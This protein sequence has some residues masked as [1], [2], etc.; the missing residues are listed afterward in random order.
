[1]FSRWKLALET[2]ANF[3]ATRAGNSRW[4]PEPFS[5]AGFQREFGLQLGKLS[6]K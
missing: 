5:G 4:N 6:Q 2:S 3:V 1:M